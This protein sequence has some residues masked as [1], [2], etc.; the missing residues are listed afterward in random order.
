MRLESA[1][2]RDGDLIPQRHGRRF[3]N[4]SPALSW[5]DVPPGTQSLALSVVDRISP[6]NVYL[7]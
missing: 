2:F 7:H 4:V 5:S 3:E 6:G 1:N